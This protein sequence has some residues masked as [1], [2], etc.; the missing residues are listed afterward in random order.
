MPVDAHHSIRH[1]SPISDG[2]IGRKGSDYLV[3]PLCRKCHQDWHAGR[4]KVA[5][6]ALLEAIVIYLVLFQARNGVRKDES[7]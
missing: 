7:C 3:I 2:G 1:L 6:D 5:R 4:L